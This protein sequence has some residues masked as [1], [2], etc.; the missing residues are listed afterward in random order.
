MKALEIYLTELLKL[1]NLAVAETSKYS[2]LQN[3][4]NTIG[5][6]VKPKVK[7]VIHPKDTGAGLPDLGLFDAHQPDGQQ[8]AH[9]VVEAKA[10]SENID[11]IARSEQ[12]RRYVKHYGQVLVT[13]YFQFA[14]VT[15]D[16]NGEPVIEE[17]FSLATNEAALWT[18]AGQV[19]KLA[20]EQGAM[21]TE[22]V[23]RVLHRNA[24]LVEPR[25][26]AWIL[27]SYAREAHIAIKRID[28]TLSEFALIRDAL[29]ESLGITF[30]SQAG[31]QFFR[32]TLIQTLFYGI[33]S[34]WVLWSETNPPPEDRF[35]LWRDTRRQAVPV[36]KELFY[37]LIDPDK[38][39]ALGIENLL[40]YTTDAL[41]R[42]ERSAF[43]ARFDSQAAVQYFYEPFLEAF[44]PE[45]RK[46]LGVWYT[47]P[48]IV[49]YMVARVDSVL[50]TELGIEAGLADPNVYVLDPCCGTGAYLVAVLN[51]IYQRVLNNGEGE[52][53]AAHAARQ[54]IT[55]RIFGF[56]ILTAPFVVAHLQL[57]LMLAH[58]G[59][60][61]DSWRDERSP[62]YE[63]VGV[64]LTNAL[65]GWQPPKDQPK[66]LF[67]Q[68]LERERDAAEVIKRGNK[69]LVVLGNPPYRAFAEKPSK[70]EDGLIE[71]YLKGLRDEWGIKKS[72][73]HELYIRFLRLAERCIAEMNETGR[74]VVCYISNFSYLN[75][76]SWVVM[77]RRFLTEFDKFWF[78]CLN[79]DSRE[80][81]KQIPKGLPGAG[82]A[83][84]SVFSTEFNREGIRVGTTVAMMVRKS[85]HDSAPTVCYR[86]FWGVTKRT[87]L[88]HSLT[89]ENFDAQY[90]IATPTQANR[91]SFRPQ[92]VS[93]LYLTWP[94][95]T[96]LCALP[97]FNGLMEK[98][99][100]ALIDIDQKAL[101]RRMRAYFDPA[102]EWPAYQA[103]GYGLTESQARF[104]PRTARKKVLTIEK[105]DEQRIRR[106]TLRPYDT[107]WCYY[108]PVR[109]IWN[110]PRPNLWAQCWAGNSFFLSRRISGTSDEGAPFFFS[111]I[112]GDDH[113]LKV[114]ASFFPIQL[115]NGKRLES[116]EQVSLF[117][118]A[119][120][121]PAED[122]P[123]ANLS[124]A[125]RTYL[126]HMGIN[127]P[128]VD[129]ATA[130]LIWLHALAIGFSPAYLS[131]HADG[132]RG[133]WP[134]IPLPANKELFLAS[135]ALG[136][137]VAD[138]L[139]TET[140]VVGVTTG[141]V[142]QELRPV[143]VL[144][145]RQGKEVNY[146]V[147][148]G[149]GHHSQGDVV[150]P[151]RGRLTV[152]DNAYDVYL[153]ETTY[154]RHVPTSVWEY[155]IGGYQ[156]L[157]KWLSYREA[158]V[159]GRALQPDE[160]REFMHIARR[161]AALS[162]LEPQLD[163]NYRA[164]TL[165]SQPPEPA[166]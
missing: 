162:A 14:L 72:N 49:E 133:D 104:D 84:P 126:A 80:T 15:R 92:S 119:G 53:T 45:L 58:W 99:G 12:V 10:T 116:K 40:L 34:A 125:A 52:L 78:D 55:T 131:E 8:P 140:P 98:R 1:R 76:P 13:N 135:A 27:A 21:L 107:R 86:D 106:Y 81:G 69:I 59:V 142:R 137:Q 9:G 115:K 71:P 95:L 42:V 57:N 120:E 127:D 6:Q 85:H 75:D 64:Y 155:T 113:L 90:R 67:L 74:G 16:A 160:T 56:E 66:Q 33:F 32:S 108:T 44:D 148:V 154:W 18:A 100:G 163:V 54:A 130:A 112:I 144:V 23:L 39:T 101:E 161:I 122:K 29:Q 24:T 65:T 123:V 41:N 83:D 31:I 68:G 153:N 109:P 70:E 61:L 150:M 63:R 158:T 60:R 103:L 129:Q 62:G 3:L 121:E 96:D 102:L 114:D 118:V 73:S 156:V 36:L 134:R 105:F 51:H 165:I 149:W 20:E 4:L 25:D 94:K 11:K 79:G 143:A 28:P 124:E 43:F 147:N 46:Q 166:Q 111:R 146:S 19:H 139:D 5:S 132:I 89:S 38:L 77:R 93:D 37:Q 7:A 17:R 88:A 145:T 50:Q 159:L 136:R 47:P 152:V 30:D 157:K 110:E 35:N 22:Y 128:D 91:Y 138:L 117:D 26:V 87:D 151:G 2:L 164:A 82:T 48:E 97:P 141:Q